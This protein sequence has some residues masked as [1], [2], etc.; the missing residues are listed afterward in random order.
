MD[1]IFELILELILEGSI[2]VSKN[3]KIYKPIR[4]FFLLLII[5]FF[6]GVIGLVFFTGILIINDN[7]IAVIFIIG[8][9]IFMLIASI[10]KFRKIYFKKR[11]KS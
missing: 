9:G 3:T 7:L 5:F 1:F 2:E 8:I 4:Y 11:I 6:I 10:I